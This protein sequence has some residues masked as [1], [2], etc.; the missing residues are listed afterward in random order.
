MDNKFYKIIVNLPKR[1]IILLIRFYQATL[2]PDHGWF[3]ARYP[4]GYC[5]YYPSCSEYGKQAIEKHGVIKGGLLA[6]KRI[7]R[8]NPWAQPRVDL[9]P[10]K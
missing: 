1:S 2:S 4:Y 8:C 10:N 9:V 6:G 5:Q 3:K 7:A